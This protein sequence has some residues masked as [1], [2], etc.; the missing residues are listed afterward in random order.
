MFVGVGEVDGGDGAHAAGVEVVDGLED[1]LA[2]V[3][4]ERA[5]VRDGLADRQPAE[6]QHLER[7]GRTLLVVGGAHGERVAGA[8]DHELVVGD[9]PAPPRPRSPGR[10]ARTPSR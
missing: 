4:H 1:L 5:V 10:G 8:E 2:G 9:R 7:V 6:Q 3:H